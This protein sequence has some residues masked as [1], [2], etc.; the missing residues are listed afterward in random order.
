MALITFLR[1]A[2][3]Y[4]LCV[5]HDAAPGHPAPEQVL[6]PVLAGPSGPRRALY[7]V[8][9]AG[10]DPWVGL[11]DRGMA[12]ARWGPGPGA[13]RGMMDAALS[14][15]SAIAG[16]ER[17]AALGLGHGA[18]LTMLGVDRGQA[19][20]ALVWDGGKLERRLFE[21]GAQC[22]CD[23]QDRATRARLRDEFGAMLERLQGADEA[24]CLA[25]QEAYHVAAWVREASAGTDDSPG[26][27]TTIC[28]DQ[29]LMLKNKGI[30][31]HADR[32]VHELKGL[33]SLFFISQVQEPKAS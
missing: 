4:S 20:L 8:D 15:D 33:P 16:L 1:L 24:E 17:V 19:P 31:R 29:I 26:G 7:P 12:F 11:N 6:Q 22:W 13:G 23:G 25:A 27:L 3:G 18:P 10:A 2:D 5:N 14:A 32:M 28:M 21:D 9:A 30:L